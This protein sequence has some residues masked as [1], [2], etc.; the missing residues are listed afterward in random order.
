MNVYLEIIEFHLHK[1]YQKENYVNCCWLVEIRTPEGKVYQQIGGES[2]GSPL[3]SLYANFYASFIENK[4][5]PY[6]KKA[7][8]FYFRHV[9]DTLLL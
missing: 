1:T 4:I 7:H 3:G 9:D 2:M 8:L 6:M 5:I